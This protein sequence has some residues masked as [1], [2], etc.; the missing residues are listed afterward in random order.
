MRL[1][2]VSEWKILDFQEDVPEYA[3]LSHTWGKEEVSLAEFQ[4]AKTTSQGYRKILN[5]CKQAISDGLD[6]VWI[7][8]CCID[9]SS[10]AELSEA[11]NSMYQWYRDSA[12]CYAYLDDVKCNDFILAERGDEVFTSSFA[13]SRWFTRG[14]TLQELLAPSIVDFYD[15]D[16]NSIGSRDEL[17]DLIAEAT[18]ID[19]RAIRLSNIDDYSIAQR[20][21]WAS[22]RR[23][24][25]IE[26]E[27]YCLL[28]LF[29]VNMPL[30]YG[31]GDKAFLRLQQEIMKESDDQSIFAWSSGTSTF[32]GS[33]QESE[34]LADIRGG[35]LAASPARFADSGH[36]VRSRTNENNTPYAVT[37]KGI[38]IKLPLF[39]A[40]TTANIQLIPARWTSSQWANHYR[41]P[42][43]TLTMAP[44][45]NLAMLNCQPADDD[46]SRYSIVIEWRAN[47]E[48]YVRVNYDL[49]LVFASLQEAKEKAELTELLIQ[50]YNKTAKI[51]TI[52]VSNPERRVI[53]QS[54]ELIERAGFQIHSTLPASS[55][56]ERLNTGT[57]A[58]STTVF[59]SN[60]RRD[61]VIEY[62]SRRGGDY[63]F[64]LVLKKRFPN[65]QETMQKDTLVGIEALAIVGTGMGEN[66]AILQSQVLDETAAIKARGE[67]IVYQKCQD[68]ELCLI[69]K[70]KEA[71]H[72]WLI[73]MQTSDAPKSEK[74]G[75][76]QRRHKMD[77]TVDFMFR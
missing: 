29:G 15:A 13:K 27:A 25:R 51:L 73:T 24:T 3:I 20:M 38:S 40:E 75:L 64:L 76:V 12:I 4:K 35:I 26:D 55:R 47:T 2:Q 46:E 39:K 67:N 58:M 10:S 9:K 23:T 74:G 72:A 37:N 36:V 44:R 49:G 50:Y 54:S 42:S 21:S 34:S 14:W 41:T 43:L 30:L 11:I 66:E 8:T 18:Q 52:P 33:R 56:W 28:G 1:L 63:R 7:D 70:V 65:S 22:H 68:G 32:K 59:L 53:I 69:P 17:A 31:E 48:S 60:G 19:I 77:L 62:R 57:V 6:Y 16:W 5:C 45:G 61:F 71:R